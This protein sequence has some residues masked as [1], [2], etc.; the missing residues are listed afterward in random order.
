[1]ELQECEREWNQ[2]YGRRNDVVDHECMHAA[3]LKRVWFKEL[4]GCERW[5][6]GPVG[7]SSKSSLFC[8]VNQ[9]GQMC[10][11]STKT[12]ENFKAYYLIKESLKVIIN[13]SVIIYSKKSV[14]EK[15]VMSLTSLFGW[16]IEAFHICVLNLHFYFPGWY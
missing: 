1:M 9:A 7:V 14:Q 3:C 5:G 8:A 6:P 12:S 16:E 10:K 2:P 15:I 4:Q 13:S 11:L